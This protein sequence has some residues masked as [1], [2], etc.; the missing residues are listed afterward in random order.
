MTGIAESRYA[1]RKGMGGITL[2][3]LNRV[4]FTYPAGFVS[5][6]GPSPTLPRPFCRTT[7]ETHG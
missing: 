1:M 2:S 7:I 6:P 3:V 4:N 5:G